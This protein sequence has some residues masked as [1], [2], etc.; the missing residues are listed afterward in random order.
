MAV[1]EPDLLWP[2]TS[3]AGSIPGGAR[4][5][6]HA[7]RLSNARHIPEIIKRRNTTQIRAKGLRD[8]STPTCTLSHTGYGTDAHVSNSHPQ[9]KHAHTRSASPTHAAHQRS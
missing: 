2:Y 8:R 3:D 7:R 9:Q 1:G 4:F 6:V 5:L